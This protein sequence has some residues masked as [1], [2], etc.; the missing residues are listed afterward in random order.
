MISVRCADVDFVALDFGVLRLECRSVD[1]EVVI[2][3]V[4]AIDGHFDWRM[5]LTIGR[6]EIVLVNV[7]GDE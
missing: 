1:S 5:L 7:F 6:S 3:G 4:T 2:D